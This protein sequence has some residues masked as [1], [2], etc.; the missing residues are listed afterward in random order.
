V[1]FVVQDTG[2]GIPPANMPRIF[3]PFFTT[4]PMSRGTG[5]GLA[6]T[7]GIVKMHRGDLQV[8]SNADPAKGPT[9][10]TFRITLPRHG[11]VD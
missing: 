5:L 2:V 1:W 3:T 8:E 4:K 6:V 7:Y 10:T 11:K 9:G